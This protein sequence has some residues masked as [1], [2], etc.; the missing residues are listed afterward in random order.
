MRDLLRLAEDFAARMVRA[1]VHYS[2]VLFFAA[3]QTE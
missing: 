3:L 2:G 1:H